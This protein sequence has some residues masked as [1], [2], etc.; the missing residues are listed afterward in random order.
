MFDVVDATQPFVVRFRARVLANEAREP[1]TTGYAFVINVR[2]ASPNQMYAIGLST[3][4]IISDYGS[5]I[6]FDTTEF[7]DYVLTATFGGDYKLYIDGQLRM[8]GPVCNECGGALNALQVGDQNN[9]GGNARAELTHYTFSQP[10]TFAPPPVLSCA[11][12]FLPPFDAVIGLKSNQQRAIPVKMVLRDASGAI[13]TDEA[14]AAPVVSVEFTTYNGLPV[15][16]TP[17]LLPLGA[18]NTDNV[19][20]FDASSQKWIYNLGT[21]FFVNPGTY[22]VVAKPGDATYQLD[23]SCRGIFV[24]RQ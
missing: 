10:A 18:A 20:R 21:E 16:V 2:T 7:H 14:I 12:G 8:V 24:R 6:P 3:S 23:S 22:A 4:F 9:L 1:Y 13:V 17:D 19:F 15:D 5:I 11:P